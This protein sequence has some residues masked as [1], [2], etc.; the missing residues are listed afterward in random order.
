MS[1]NA[2]TDIIIKHYLKGRARLFVAVLKK[3]KTGLSLVLKILRGL[4]GIK[5]AEGSF[6]TGSL[7]VYF[8]EGL[9]SLERVISS[10]GEALAGEPGDGY[11]SRGERNVPDQIQGVKEPEDRP[12]QRQA[13]NVVLG[14]GVLGFLVSKYAILGKSTLAR[15][16]K[17]FNLA[18]ATTIISGYPI[19]KSG[20]KNMA[21]RGRINHDLVMGALSLG[22]LLMRESVPGLLVVWLVNLN[23]LIQSL[24]LARSRKAVE[25]FIAESDPA[26]IYA[27]KKTGFN[28]YVPKELPSMR[29]PAEEYADKIVPVSL[30]LAAVGAITTRDFNVALASLLAASPSPAGLARPG[31]LSAATALA[32]KNGILVREPAAFARLKDVD[33]VIFTGGSLPGCRPE[34]VEALPLPGFS[35][36]EIISLTRD[37]LQKNQSNNKGNDL[38]GVIYNWSP[39]GISVSSDGRDILIGSKE[40]ISQSGVNTYPALLKEKRLW[41]RRMFPLY[42]ARN[43]TLAGVLGFK[44]H[45]SDDTRK[46]INNIRSRGVTGIYIIA[47]EDDLAAS[48][49]ATELGLTMIPPFQGRGAADFILEL[50]RGGNVVAAV[51]YDRGDSCELA[52]ADVKIVYKQTSGGFLLR[53]ADIILVRENLNLVGDGI[54]LSFIASEKE[55]QN[56]EITSVLNT[57]GLTLALSRC[58]SPVS[59][60]LYNNLISIAV[61]L[62]SLRIYKQPFHSP[63]PL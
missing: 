21:D 12:V 15:S 24:V 6:S 58:L 43:G 46:A 13:L 54:A 25:E 26:G 44:Q 51:S 39:D 7:L 33:S 3:D 38:K 30:G 60:S 50:K 40:F 11:H 47:D 27:H 17:L 62:N 49:L 10:V 36:A 5:R 56:V 41:L 1:S 34:V 31:A 45:I 2:A 22:T 28:T 59:A 9:L 19:F 18:A 4:P 61:S 48:S 42:V 29:T 23:S 16:E 35:Q 8:E 20:V 63:K 37:A 57:L 32:M 55:R 14:G 52:A 53:E